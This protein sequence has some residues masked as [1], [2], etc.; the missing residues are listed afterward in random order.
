MGESATIL[1]SA[2]GNRWSADGNVT[3]D[4]GFDEICPRTGG[5]EPANFSSY[6]PSF[7]LVGQLSVSI[8]ESTEF[9]V[10]PGETLCNRKRVGKRVETP[11]PFFVVR[12][13]P[14][15]SSTGVSDYTS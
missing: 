11:H 15:W 4:T 7:Y 3:I 6:G 9:R 5:I 12:P 10:L 1:R 8:M 13:R 14:F 2:G